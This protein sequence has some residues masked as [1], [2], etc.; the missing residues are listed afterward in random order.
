MTDPA[1][2]NINDNQLNETN[3]PDKQQDEKLQ[4]Q[5]VTQSAA[6][7]GPIPPPNILSGY[8]K[9]ESGLANRI[10]IMAENESI[11]RRQLQVNEQEIYK[12]ETL[13]GQKFA[14][15]IGLTGIIV[16]GLVAGLASPIAG[17]ILGLGTIGALVSAFIV[18]R[19]SNE[20]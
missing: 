18:G 20:N 16:S 19:K 2:H 5:Q 9:I 13:R 17:G 4:L 3:P 6:F 10:V 1:D 12:A 7:S 15:I 11:H 14:L 8:E